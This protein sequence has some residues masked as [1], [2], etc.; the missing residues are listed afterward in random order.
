V[1]TLHLHPNDTD[2]EPS[3]NNSTGFCSFLSLLL[4][5]S[6]ETQAA[7]AVCVRACSSAY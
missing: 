1:A 6:R 3:P 5:H 7:A 4:N 2:F